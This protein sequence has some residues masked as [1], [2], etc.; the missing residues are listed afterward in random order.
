MNI[1]DSKSKNNIQ[2]EERHDRALASVKTLDSSS[3]PKYGLV[4]GILFL[5]FS[6]LPAIFLTSSSRSSIP[7]IMVAA[8]GFGFA[9]A[10]WLFYAVPAKLRSHNL[11]LTV[12]LIV[13]LFAFVGIFS[14]T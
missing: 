2:E 5:V 12:M 6:I 7:F 8:E 3:K 4:F 14:K 10:A 13:L 11:G 9:F 1:E